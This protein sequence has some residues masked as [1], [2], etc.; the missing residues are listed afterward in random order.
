MA[1]STKS[2][3]KW[4]VGTSLARTVESWADLRQSSALR[5]L[6][7]PFWSD[8]TMGRPRTRHREGDPVCPNPKCG[9][10]QTCV[11][12]KRLAVAGPITLPSL[13][14][15]TSSTSRAGPCSPGR[16]E[17]VRC[18]TYLQLSSRGWHRGIG[19]SR[20]VE[21]LADP[22]DVGVVESLSR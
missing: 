8:W 5:S 10:V 22:F 3:T 15:S 2:R 11:S 9:E 14:S 16:A 19:S 20:V 13:A 6:R 17:D 7:S 12:S 21:V 18:R 4:W 1:M